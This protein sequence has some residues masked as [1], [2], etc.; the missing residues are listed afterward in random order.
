VRRLI[1]Q[2]ALRIPLE[3]EALHDLPAGGIAQLRA[4]AQARAVQ[5]RRREP[6]RS[7]ISATPPVLDAG[8]RSPS[9]GRLYVSVPGWHSP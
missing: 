3:R 6:P 9:W 7:R 2:P 1:V 8:R 4:V 5:V